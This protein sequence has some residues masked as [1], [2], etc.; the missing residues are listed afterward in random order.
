VNALFVPQ[1]SF[2]QLLLFL[3]FEWQGQH[4]IVA[5]VQPW[6]G[7]AWINVPYPPNLLI[8]TQRLQAIDIN[9]ILAPAG[10]VIVSGGRQVAF[11]TSGGGRLPNLVDEEEDGDGMA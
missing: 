5:I 11:D 8:K 9:S 7:E 2:G 4:I 6:E 1:I 10:R 3:Q